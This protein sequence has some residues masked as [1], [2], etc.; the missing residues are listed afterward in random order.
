MVSFSLL[1]PGLIA[2]DQISPVEDE[3][4]K[5]EGENVSL[6][7][8]YETNSQNV[9]LYWYRHHSDLQAPQFI[10]WKGARDTTDKYIPDD[11]YQCKTGSN[12]TEL[13]IS[14]LTLAD[15]ALYYCALET[16]WYKVEKR[17]YKKLNT[18]MGLLFREEGSGIQ[19]TA[20]YQMDSDQSHCGYSC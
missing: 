10:L 3:L 17:L 1:F 6:R 19:T 15:T 11:R 18:D 13:T 4:S 16:Q 14:R 20:S 9:W 2:G 12:S 5:R 7:C 8:D